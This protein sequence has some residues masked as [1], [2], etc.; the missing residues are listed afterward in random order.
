MIRNESNW[1]E[2]LGRECDNNFECNTC[3]DRA[4]LE[5]I[6]KD[7]IMAK[8]KNVSLSEHLDQEIERGNSPKISSNLKE[9]VE[10]EGLLMTGNESKGCGQLDRGYENNFETGKLKFNEGKPLNISI[11]SIYKI[12]KLILS[13]L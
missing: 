4:V 12:I 6:K 9:L 7:I 2:E 5:I 10:K 13:F 11:F 3:Y 1:C 8:I